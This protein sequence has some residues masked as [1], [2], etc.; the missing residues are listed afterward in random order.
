MET[1]YSFC[2]S[3]AL[4][5]R[6]GDNIVT[7]GRPVAVDQLCPELCN[8][9]CPE[10]TTTAAATRATTATTA[11]P[12]GNTTGD[13]NAT[14][15]AAPPPPSPPSGPT[16]AEPAHPAG[17]NGKPDPAI[18]AFV[19][20]DCNAETSLSSFKVLDLCPFLCTNC[21][22]PES[23]PPAVTTMVGPD[24][25]IGEICS[26]F[27]SLGNTLG[28]TDPAFCSTTTKACKDSTEVPGLWI[29]DLC[30]V[31]CCDQS[32][33]SSTT[34]A[35][36]A[37]TTATTT[38]ATAVAGGPTT[39]EANLDGSGSSDDHDGSGKDTSSNE[40]DGQYVD[41][42]KSTSPSRP[43]IASSGVTTT[44]AGGTTGG[45]GNTSE[46]GTVAAVDADENKVG[47]SN[48]LLWLLLLLLLIPIL[49][50]CKRRREEMLA[51]EDGDK[52]G[53][54]ESTELDVFGSNPDRRASAVTGVDRDRTMEDGIVLPNAR[55]SMSNEEFESLVGVLASEKLNSAAAPR[56]VSSLGSNKKG[57][58]QPSL[59]ISPGSAEMQHGVPSDG[60]LLFNNNFPSFDPE[61]PAGNAHQNTPASPAHPTIIYPSSTLPVNMH[62]TTSNGVVDALA[63]AGVTAAALAAARGGP[64]A[65]ASAAAAAAASS[66]VYDNG[67]Y[68]HFDNVHGN[69]AHIRAGAP[70][71]SAGVAPTPTDAF[72]AGEYQYAGSGYPAGAV[73]PTLTDVHFNAEYQ[74]AGSAAGGNDDDGNNNGVQFYD[75]ASNK[76]RRSGLDLSADSDGYGPG[77]I[78]ASPHGERK[79][80]D[81]SQVSELRSVS[82]MTSQGSGNTIPFPE[83]AD[84]RGSTPNMVFGSPGGSVQGSSLVF[85]PRGTRPYPSS[86]P[87]VVSGVRPRSTLYEVDP[88]STMNAHG[89]PVY[90]HARQD[91]VSRLT[92]RTSG[93]ILGVG[94]AGANAYDIAGGGQ[95]VT[96]MGHAYDL[97]SGEGP[98][99]ELDLD[100]SAVSVGAAGDAAGDAVY[101]LSTMPLHKTTKDQDY[102]LGQGLRLQPSAHALGSASSDSATHR[103]LSPYDLA[104]DPTS[105]Q[106]QQPNPRPAVRPLSVYDVASPALSLGSVAAMSA[107]QASAGQSAYTHAAAGSGLHAQHAY[108]FGQQHGENVPR[109]PSYDHAVQGS[110]NGN[111]QHGG[112]YPTATY[113]DGNIAT[114]DPYLLA[115]QNGRVGASIRGDRDGSTCGVYPMAHRQ[116]GDPPWGD[117]GEAPATYDL[118]NQTLAGVLRAG[119]FEA[120]T[121]GTVGGGEAGEGY[122][123]AGRGR[124]AGEDGSTAYDV[125]SPLPASSSPAYDLSTAYPSQAAAA[126][127]GEDAYAVGLEQAVYTRGFDEGVQDPSSEKLPSDDPSSPQF[128]RPIE[129]LKSKH[130]AVRKRV[131]DGV[132]NGAATGV[133][134]QEGGVAE[135]AAIQKEDDSE[136]EDDVVITELDL[137]SPQPSTKRWS[138]FTSRF[139]FSKRNK[140]GATGGNDDDA[141]AKQDGRKGKKK[142]KGKRFGFSKRAKTSAGSP[143]KKTEI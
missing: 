121:T 63:A 10:T 104:S 73:S 74:Y 58:G 129:R 36:M 8:N 32:T 123:L 125:A 130:V 52:D 34:T 25:R 117:G 64:A 18:C 127:G 119:I 135:P 77:Y 100:D 44:P 69:G 103:P 38:T 55:G 6:C 20:A 128:V 60:M 138:K 142:T 84:G 1:D 108:S 132:G 109:E 59:I 141:G 67:Y 39:A 37:T 12:P 102:A 33:T 7:A 107:G 9:K 5:G 111:H 81:A 90:D 134:I 86:E 116:S 14:T 120:G 110:L 143:V 51:E 93:D 40:G 41:D 4:D 83:D 76:N 48:N 31:K 139:G 97:I 137:F 17:C 124:V 26:E 70:G 24:D 133:V 43:I 82:R 122:E 71:A 75:S 15:T 50:W 105:P 140:G 22:T 30:L 89:E 53:W 85:D 23:T 114:S 118:A 49:F 91:G 113:S 106:R 68:H 65:A 96:A 42:D 61:W 87:S 94:A 54:A 115:Q 2:S 13:G 66:D 27:L 92:A 80:S 62:A 19:G 95:V 79:H 11:V 46:N 28:K 56:R 78:L 99:D 112:V 45:S 16:T 72:D 136:E 57:S 35:T 131:R 98:G 101:D 29:A 88:L 3:G 21:S 47:G 126:S